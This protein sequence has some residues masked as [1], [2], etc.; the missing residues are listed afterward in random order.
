MN[1]NLNKIVKEWSYRVHDGMPDIKDP[2][3][4]VEL[5]QVLH[6]RKYPRKFIETLLNRLRESEASEKA[7]EM[8]LVHL[9]GGAYGREEGGATTHVSKEGELVPVGDVKAKKGTGE[10][11]DKAAAKKAAKKAAKVAAK[12]KAKEEKEKR[13]KQI[14]DNFE[15]A[16]DVL[17][18]RDDYDEDEIQLA[19][20]THGHHL[21]QLSANAGIV[22]PIPRE[23]FTQQSAANLQHAGNKE[24]RRKNVM[25]LLESKGFTAK[26]FKTKGKA[27]E[28]ILDT[29]TEVDK[30]EYDAILE[31]IN[32][33]INIADLPPTGNLVDIFK[34]RGLSEETIRK[35][36][37]IEP[38]ADASGSAIGKG[39]VALALLCGDIQNSLEHGDLSRTGPEGE[40]IGL[41]IKGYGGRPG[42][43]PGRGSKS[44]TPLGSWIGKSLRTTLASSSNLSS[45]EQEEVLAAFK[46]FGEN[47]NN[48]GQIKQMKELVRILKEKDISDDVILDSIQAQ[49]ADVYS[50]SVDPTENRQLVNEY[51]NDMSMFEG[52]TE[53]TPNAVCQKIKNQL[54][55]LSWR[56]YMR[57]HNVN[58]IL[59][60]DTNL[61]DKLSKKAHPKG[62]KDLNY[63]VATIDTFDDLVDKGTITTKT[64][65]PCSGFGLGESAPNTIAIPNVDENGNATGWTSRE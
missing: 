45:E 31:L 59:F 46:L 62:I 9:G 1:F 20:E 49:L 52:D 39:E 25:E 5:Q 8:G 21:H 30:E 40:I 33:P 63:S 54:I 38:G 13:R 19:M 64:Q 37:N 51:F 56:A 41:E 48:A 55:K 24:A 27:L 32:N 43:Q 28:L 11:E 2:L 42:Q 10:P 16:T 12:K 35:L 26:R 15:V 60:H 4:M 22:E 47:K 58:E 7:K 57:Q 36:M 44:N 34:E 65:N 18:N 61:K 50:F 53:E 23:D 6:E 29:I 3:H 17:R 14:Y